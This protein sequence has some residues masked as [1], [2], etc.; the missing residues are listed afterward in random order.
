M[1]VKFSSRDLGFYMRELIRE[2]LEP[3]S[4]PPDV[5]ISVSEHM[6]ATL[7]SAQHM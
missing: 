7:E 5:A 6:I 4:V 2:G 3:D 1:A